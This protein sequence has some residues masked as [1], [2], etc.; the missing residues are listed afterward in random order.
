MRSALEIDVQDVP[1][2]D[3]V[4]TWITQRAMK[5]AARHP[6]ITKL[7]VSVDTP[8]K[9]QSKGRRF[10]VQIGI[11]VPGLD[12]VAHNHPSAS[13]E[14]LMPALYEAFDR[15]ERQLD[16]LRSARRNR[17]RRRG[18]GEAWQ[19]SPFATKAASASPAPA[20]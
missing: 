6:G 12:V 15:S 3:S 4:R 5:L 10:R 18:K 7:R 16:E 8:H 13:S 14:K 20:Q 2:S 19:P 1:E 9:R 11:G 17:D